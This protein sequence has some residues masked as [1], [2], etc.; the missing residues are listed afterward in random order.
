[1]PT[2]RVESGGGVCFCLTVRDG[3]CAYV[4]WE[5]E[6]VP[7]LFFFNRVISTHDAYVEECGELNPLRTASTFLETIYLDFVE[8]NI[9]RSNSV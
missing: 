1:M 4:T 2:R 8:D 9:F 6:S 3:T 5:Q 7:T